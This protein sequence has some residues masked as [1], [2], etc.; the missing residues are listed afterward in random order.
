MQENK[1][2]MFCSNCGSENSTIS[3]FCSSCGSELNKVKLENRNNTEALNVNISENFTKVAS[4]AQKIASSANVDM[5]LESDD[6]EK[7]VSSKVDYYSRKFRQIKDTGSKITWNWASFFLNVYWMLYRKMYAQAGIVFLIN[8]LVVYAMPSGLNSI[9]SLG[10][11]VAV[12]M[13]GNYMYLK[14]VEKKLA[15][16]N[17]LNHSEREY[18]I[19]KKGGTNLL[20]PIVVAILTVVVVAL[21]FVF[22]SSMFFYMLY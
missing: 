16:M 7:F 11:Q 19:R 17:H 21:L 3:T 6:V 22:L 8:I 2:I 1:D 12:G 20:I 18:M 10:V 5:N 13:Y 4:S 9:L 14:H 15:D